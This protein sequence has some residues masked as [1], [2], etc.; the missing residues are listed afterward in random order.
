MNAPVAATDLAMLSMTEA[1]DAFAAGEVKASALVDACLARIDA[2]GGRVK[3]SS[4][5]IATRRWKPRGRGRCAR[6]PPASRSAGWPA[7][8]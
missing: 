1:A 8:R 4:A 6:A 2:H 3:P 5:W 7:C